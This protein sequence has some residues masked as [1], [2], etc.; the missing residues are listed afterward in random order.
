MYAL[1][2]AHVLD[3]IYQQCIIY[4]YIAEG[5]ISMQGRVIKIPNSRCGCFITH[6]LEDKGTFD[7]M[8]CSQSMYIDTSIQGFLF[9]DHGPR[10]A[11]CALCTVHCE[12]WTVDC[13]LQTA[14]PVEM[15]RSF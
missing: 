4:V 14:P 9:M 7:S 11:D 10:T 2:Y 12:L 5:T 8:S 1:T 13:R 6:L 3:I 15:N